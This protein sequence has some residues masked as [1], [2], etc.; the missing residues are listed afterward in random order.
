MSLSGH[1]TFRKKTTSKSDAGLLSTRLDD[2]TLTLTAIK[3]G[4]VRKYVLLDRTD[5]FT[6]DR[7]SV[8]IHADYD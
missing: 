2:T 7:M 6:W 4:N 3:L 5:I 1:Y 8:I